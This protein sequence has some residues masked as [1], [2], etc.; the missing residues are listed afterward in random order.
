MLLT[1]R[2]VRSSQGL[3]CSSLFRLHIQFKWPTV[4]VTYSLQGKNGSHLGRV[5][6]VSHNCNVFVNKVIAS[7]PVF[8]HCWFAQLQICMSYENS[9]RS[10]TNGTQR[11]ASKADSPPPEDTCWI[12]SQLHVWSPM[13]LANCWIDLW[14]LRGISTMHLNLHW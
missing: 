9:T 8:A 13:E 14:V 6:A 2:E 11:T 5:R 1:K 4:Q 7:T 12:L 3:L 10:T